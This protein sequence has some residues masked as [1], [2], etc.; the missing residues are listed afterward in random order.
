MSDDYKRDFEE[1]ES[2][3]ETEPEGEPVD[4][5]EQKQRELVT[6]VVDYN[7]GTLADLIGQNVIDLAPKYQ[8]RFRWN[9]VRQSMLIE[10]FLMN[11]PVP[12]IFLNE[13]EYGKY[14]V[15]DGKQR[16]TAIWRYVSDAFPL[17][18]TAEFSDLGGPRWPALVRPP[19]RRKG[20]SAVCEYHRFE[21]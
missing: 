18:R 9:T 2:L 3:L 6:N 4:F 8:R 11:V 12:P 21:D 17:L 20:P 15:I 5:W 19:R 16:L 14:S 13:D 1:P 10:S 7:L